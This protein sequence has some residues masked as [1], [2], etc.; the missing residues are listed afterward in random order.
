MAQTT[1]Q[2]SRRHALIRR[3]SRAVLLV[4][5]ISATGWAQE[6]NPPAYVPPPPA[7]EVVA[8]A[9]DDLPQYDQLEVHQRQAL[10]R[11]RLSI[12]YYHTD[13]AERY[14]YINGASA[15]EGAPIGQ[16]LWVHEITP[17]GVVLRYEDTF[18]WLPAN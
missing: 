5:I 17:D 12:H 3:S 14:I 4:V 13:A 15:R 9:I 1:L 8:P 11:P 6:K 18:F 10:Q 7:R 16:E 2:S